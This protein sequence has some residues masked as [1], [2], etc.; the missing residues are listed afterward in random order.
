[1]KRDYSKLQQEWANRKAAVSDVFKMEPGTDPGTPRVKKSPDERK[2][3]LA[4]VVQSEISKGAGRIESQSDYYVT[5][6]RGH[7]PNH[8]LH[9]ILSI[10]TLGLWIIV[11]ILV[12][13]GSGEK[14]TMVSVDEYGYVMTRR[15]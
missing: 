10:I 9:L 13:M 4:Q 8:I 11:W 7:R 12:A 3:L 2:Q 14:R 1:M 15:I 6:V 5:L